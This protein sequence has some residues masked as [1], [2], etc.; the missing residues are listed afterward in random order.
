VQENNLGHSHNYIC[1]TA[2]FVFIKILIF[3]IDSRCIAE[4]YGNT[5]LQF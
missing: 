1:V 3:E 4:V 5:D 2:V